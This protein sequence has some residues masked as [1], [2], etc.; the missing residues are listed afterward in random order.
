MVFIT[1]KTMYSL[2]HQKHY[3]QCHLT[4]SSNIFL[5]S[6][7]TLKMS[8]NYS[9]SSIESFWSPSSSPFTLLSSKSISVWWKAHDWHEANQSKL[10]F[11]LSCSSTRAFKRT[12]CIRWFS[13]YTIITN[14]LGSSSNY[15]INLDYFSNYCCITDL[16]WSQQ[17]QKQVTIPHNCFCF[18]INIFI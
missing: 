3:V 12:H 9:E 11:F 2:K 15:W 16:Q 7:S 17:Q 5:E 10:F 4:Q 6:E 13:Y 1:Y 8:W 18:S 14:V